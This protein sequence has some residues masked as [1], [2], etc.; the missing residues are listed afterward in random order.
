MHAAGSETSSGSRPAG[1]IRLGQDLP[2]DAPK[3]DSLVRQSATDDNSYSR[4]SNFSQ[5]RRSAL[6]RAA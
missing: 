3:P 1:I 2:F 5:T 6:R 4:R